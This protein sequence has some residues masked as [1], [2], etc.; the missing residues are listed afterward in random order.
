MKKNRQV[1]RVADQAA[2][3]RVPTQPL[4]LPL[5]KPSISNSTVATKMVI[6]TDVSVLLVAWLEVAIP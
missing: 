3:T 6:D 4:I 1:P 5:V 2:R